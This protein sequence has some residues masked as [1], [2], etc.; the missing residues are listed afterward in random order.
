MDSVYPMLPG[1]NEPS[2]GTIRRHKKSQIEARASVHVRE[3]EDAGGTAVTPG[4]EALGNSK[5]ECYGG[6]AACNIQD[7]R[8]AGA[9]EIMT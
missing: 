6:S 5:T 2:G 7:A 9:H 3:T 8:S 1:L 4:I